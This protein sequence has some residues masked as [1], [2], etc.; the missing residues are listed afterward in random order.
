MATSMTRLLL[1][2]AVALFE[3]VNGYQIRRELQSWQVDQWANVNPGSIYH[4]LGS[5]VAN[6][7]AIRHDLAEGGRTVAVYQ[8]TP[9]GRAEFDRLLTAAVAEVNVFDRRDFHAAFGLLPLI[10][11]ARAADL[12]EA[13]RDALAS[14]LAEYPEKATAADHPD[15]PP[16]AIR[17]MDLWGAEARAELRWLTEVV[18]D[19]H[20]GELTLRPDDWVPPADDPGHQMTADRERYL[21]LINGARDAPRS[22]IE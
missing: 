18:A 19:L 14:A 6:D 16:H 8:L 7:L 17:G 4:G 21:A 15:V 3:P 2:G 11:P 1:L 9:R 12:L 13:R 20:S 5:L 10:D 22:P